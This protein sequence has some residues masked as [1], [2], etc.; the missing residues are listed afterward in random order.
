MQFLWTSLMAITVLK[1]MCC[2]L[3]SRRRSRCR[4]RH[5]SRRSRWR[6][7]SHGRSVGA[8]WARRRRRRR[9]IWSKRWWRAIR[10]SHSTRLLLRNLPSP[11]LPYPCLPLCLGS[12]LSLGREGVFIRGAAYGLVLGGVPTLAV[13]RTLT[14]SAN[15]PS[16]ACRMRPRKCLLK[17]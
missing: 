9:W 3:H 15:W 13:S 5:R 17:S 10:W 6:P 8:S 16:V 7:G 12:K 1:N 4:C 2:R 14:L 11:S